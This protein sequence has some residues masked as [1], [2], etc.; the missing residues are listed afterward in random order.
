MEKIDISLTKMLTEQLSIM[1]EVQFDKYMVHSLSQQTR[2]GF[3]DSYLNLMTKAYNKPGKLLKGEHLKP[4]DAINLVRNFVQRKDSYEKIYGIKEDDIIDMDDLNYMLVL[5]KGPL[6]RRVLE[7]GTTKYINRKSTDT[8]KTYQPTEFRFA[9][10]VEIA[11]GGIFGIKELGEVNFNRITNSVSQN[12]YFVTNINDIRDTYVIK[13]N[14]DNEAVVYDK[15]GKKY[16]HITR[17]L[18]MNKGWGFME[19]HGK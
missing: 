5:M 6:T 13:T 18:L 3:P 17:S 9:R 16:E 19:K 8:W 7:A 2:Y 11:S 4:E 15:T 14:K 10:F 1:L 12:L